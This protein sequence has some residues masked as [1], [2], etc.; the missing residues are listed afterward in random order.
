MALANSPSVDLDLELPSLDEGNLT[1]SPPRISNE[2]FV[3][4]VEESRGRLAEAGELEQ[5][6]RESSRPVSQV[7]VID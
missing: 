3:E 2:A 7:F 1:A 6:L 4:F 5:C